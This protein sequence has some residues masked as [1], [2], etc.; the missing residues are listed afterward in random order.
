[1]R[2]TLL[3]YLLI[4]PCLFADGGAN[5]TK[6]GGAILTNFINETTTLGSASGDLKGALGVSVLSVTPGPNGSTVFHNQHQWV[7]E[8]GDTI[9]LAPANA[10][11]YP[12]PAAP[13]L[14]SA[15]YSS[16]AQITGGTGRFAGASGSLAVFGALNLTLGQVVLRYSGQVCFAAQ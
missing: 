13:G 12:I 10:T 16:G 9:F 5:C 1:M 15:V 11:A 4:A 3:G 2:T 6:V 8:A 7:T 14:F